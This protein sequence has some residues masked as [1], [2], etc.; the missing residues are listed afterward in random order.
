MKHL[1]F[2]FVVV[3]VAVATTLTFAQDTEP[4][5]KFST[6][7]F[8]VYGECGMCKNRIEKA[9]QVAG[10]KTASWNVDTKQLNVVYNPK[11]IS[12][13]KIH[14]LIAAVGH[15]TSKVKAED[16]VYNALPGCCHYQRKP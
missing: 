4:K 7:S 11:V 5:N 1:K 15:D 2:L 13:E 9:L 8:T 6:T 14:T 16:K 12:L 10:V 3:L